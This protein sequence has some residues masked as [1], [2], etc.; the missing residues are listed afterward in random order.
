MPTPEARP[1]PTP[2]LA[3]PGP[4]PAGGLAGAREFLT[5]GDFPRAAQAFESAL[6]SEASRRFTIQVL[7]ACVPETVQK[8]VSAAPG[9]DLM[10]FSAS[11]NGKSCYRM[12]W[13]LF[14]T[15][16]QA[17][18]ALSTVPAHFRGGG[19]PKAQKLENL[20]K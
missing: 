14:D 20:L 3:L 9:N 13:G 11:V 17:K 19:T 8:A 15:E 2:K 5:S 10:L 6:R 12:A 16:T 1:I 4:P 18:A 7:V